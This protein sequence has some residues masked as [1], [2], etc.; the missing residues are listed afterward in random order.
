MNDEL[1]QSWFGL[2][3][4]AEIGSLPDHACPDSLDFR[5][6]SIYSPWHS[7]GSWVFKCALT[8]LSPLLQHLSL[9]GT[10]SA[11]CVLSEPN[12][13]KLFLF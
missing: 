12:G 10:P 9:L 2:V 5:F 13:R 4:V 3:L 8:P 6:P 1:E 11:L 7:T